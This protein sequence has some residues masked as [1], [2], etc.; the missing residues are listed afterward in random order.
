[1]RFIEDYYKDIQ[2]KIKEAIKNPIQIHPDEEKRIEKIFCDILEKNIDYG[3]DD[4]Y[5]I[6]DALEPEF[7]KYTK[8]IILEIA[9]YKLRLHSKKKND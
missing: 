2:K 6:I 8:N 7:S 9:L 5:V 3:V 1:L 4:V